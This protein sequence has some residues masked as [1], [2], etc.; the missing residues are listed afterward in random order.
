MNAFLVLS[1][2]LSAVALLGSGAIFAQQ[3]STGEAKLR[4][5][6]RATILQ[7]RTAETERATLQAAQ[8]ASAE[9]TKELTAKLEELAKQSAANQQSSAKE[10]AALTERVAEKEIA[11]VQLRETLEKWK[12]SYNE[13]AELARKKEG[14]RAAL[15]SEKIVLDRRVADQQR[16]NA[17]M[18]KIGN[19]ILVRYEKFGLGTAIAAREPFVGTMR[20][21]LQNLVQDY[22]DKLAEQKIKPEPAPVPE[23]K[24]K[25]APAK[26]R[27]G[28][29]DS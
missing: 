2:R 29:A 8:T 14:E 6:L 26:A 1:L 22:S 25:P 27:E 4:E 20:V 21:K 10:I 13:A 18:F 16:K 3:P 23:G 17:E 12:K 15:A 9:E 7:L 19:E 11:M 5:Q 28:R 24:A